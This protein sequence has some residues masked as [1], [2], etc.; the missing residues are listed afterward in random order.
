MIHRPRRLRRGQALRDLV[1]QT[2]VTPADFILP[3]FIIP[4]R[5]KSRPVKSMPGVSQ[6]T[7]D[8]AVKELKRAEKLGV[9]GYILF[10]VTPAQAKD[11]LG[12]HAHA[13]DNEV[14]TAVRRAKDAGIDMVAISDLCFCEY[15]SHGHCGKLCDD[16]RLVVDN[17][18]TLEMLGAQ[19]V[20]HARAGFDVIAPSGM[21]D[22]TVAALRQALDGEG[23]DHIA[24]LSYAVKYASA[25]YGPF[26]DAAQSAPGKGDR[27]GYQMDFRNGREALREALLDE[28]Q[29]A[30]MLMVKPGMA[31]LDI[32]A[33][34][35][36]HTQLPL[37][38][39][40]VSGEYAMLKAAAQNGWL[41]GER[42]LRESVYAFKRAGADMI[43]TYAA[44]E[45][46]ERASHGVV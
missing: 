17:D 35:R 2:V 9:R 26:R 13:P 4:G 27:Q 33:K 16:E 24:I 6:L 40:Q 10:G 22:G 45:L 25:F 44:C 36:E 11:E 12:R 43:L 46:A 23:F 1:A 5:G 21:M 31:Y 38:V 18:A 15:T 34:L 28:Q 30:D 8:L 42:V 41:D 14:C 29:G 37:A 7:P 3:L 32:L 20:N 19:A 39:Y